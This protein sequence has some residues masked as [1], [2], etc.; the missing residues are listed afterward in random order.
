MSVF[1]TWG[2]QIRA[3]AIT[4]ALV[5][6]PV[7]IDQALAPAAASEPAPYASPLELAMKAASN[8]DDPLQALAALED[9]LASERNRPPESFEAEIGLLPGCRD[10]RANAAG[11]VVGYLVDT[12]PDATLENLCAHMEQRGWTS[13][14]L[15]G[16]TG[17]TFL[18][19]E[20]ACTWTMAT[21]TQVDESTCI[22][23]RG[24][25]E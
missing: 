22:V 9:A 17:A 6:S 12:P 21:L 10:V 5:L 13:V 15:G 24:E 3:V 16:V 1:G 19:G 8:A 25:F 11:N 4:A 14:P 2:R 7:A 18:K 23:M 20:G